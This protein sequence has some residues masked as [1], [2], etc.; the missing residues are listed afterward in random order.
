MVGGPAQSICFHT[1]GILIDNN[2]IQLLCLSFPGGRARQ[3][4][5][6]FVCLLDNSFVFCF[7]PLTI[8]HYAALTMAISLS[9]I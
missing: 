4:H 2:Y 5:N 9:G 1:N 3:Q 8:K 7:A 6:S